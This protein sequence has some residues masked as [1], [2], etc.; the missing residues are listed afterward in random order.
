MNFSQSPNIFVHK[1]P[2]RP[3]FLNVVVF[4][5]RAV[6]SVVVVVVSFRSARLRLVVRFEDEND[7]SIDCK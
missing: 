2:A 6:V 5:V 1:S 7:E 4:V 3:S